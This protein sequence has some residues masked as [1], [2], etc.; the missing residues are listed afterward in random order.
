MFG[1]TELKSGEYPLADGGRMIVADDGSRKIIDQAGDVQEFT[2]EGAPLDSGL[3]D[4]L[5][6]DLERQYREEQQQYDQQMLEDY[7]NYYETQAP[8]YYQPGYQE[9]YGL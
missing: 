2:K 9:D 4:Q 8:E 1:S 3:S 5:L 7:Q 6:A